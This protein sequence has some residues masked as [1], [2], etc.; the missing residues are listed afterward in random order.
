[1]ELSRIATDLFAITPSDSTDQNFISIRCD[2]AG[3]LRIKT[4]SNPTPVNLNVSAGEVI[5][6]LVTRV[7]AT[8]TTAT[9]HG[10]R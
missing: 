2:S 5:P 3:T 10:Y 6:V 8:G 9:V 4:N 7:Y 1:M